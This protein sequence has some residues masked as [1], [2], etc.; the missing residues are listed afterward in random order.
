MSLRDWRASMTQ[1]AIAN[2]AAWADGRARMAAA[3]AVSAAAAVAAFH[4]CFGVPFVFDDGP[5]TLGNASIRSLWPVWGALSPPAGTTVAGRPIANLTL[6]INFALSGTGPWSYH[7]LNLLIHIL[8]GLTLFGIVRRTMSMPVLSGRFGRD[9]APV[10]LATA[11]LWTLHPLQ[12]EAVT[13]VVQRVES[14]MALFYLLTLYCFIRSA[15]SARPRSGCSPILPRPIL[16]GARPCSRPVAGT[17][18]SPSTGESCS[19]SPGIP[20]R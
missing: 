19:C 13:Y 5:A 16:R 8:G 15:E 1:S 11:L 12:T 20:R 3:A 4:N 9:A 2:R 17:R 10:A 7:A 18:R 6:A 14:L